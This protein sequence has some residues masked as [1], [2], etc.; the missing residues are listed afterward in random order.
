MYI[1]I[2]IYSSSSNSGV[3]DALT[4]NAFCPHN[5]SAESIPTTATTESVDFRSLGLKPYVGNPRS[6]ETPPKSRFC[7]A[8]FMNPCTWIQGVYQWRL[9]NESQVHWIQG[10]AMNPE[11]GI[12]HVGLNPTAIYPQALRPRVNTILPL[13]K[14]CGMYCNNG[15]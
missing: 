6:E 15:G 13:P 11:P 5:E 3:W 7:L 9:P 1:C 10:V 8:H 12:A 4:K 2:C 14:L